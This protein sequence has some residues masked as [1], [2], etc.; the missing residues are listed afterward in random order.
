[1]DQ[2]NTYIVSWFHLF[3]NNVVQFD[4]IN[5][6]F[7]KVK[8]IECHYIGDVDDLFFDS[9]LSMIQEI[10]S[11][12]YSVLNWISL[13]YINIKYSSDSFFKYSTQ[14]K[15]NGWKLQQDNE[16]TPCNNPIC[17]NRNFYLTVSRI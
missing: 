2:W 3:D 1:M 11:L 9:L 16:Y 12:T 10:N 14:Y 7:K 15:H 4:K 5:K 8:Y 17:Q 6:I 13:R